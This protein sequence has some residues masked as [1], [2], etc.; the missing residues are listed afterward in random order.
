MQLLFLSAA[1]MSCSASTSS[2]TQLALWRDSRRLGKRLSPCKLHPPFRHPEEALSI[3]YPLTATSDLRQN[4]SGS[5]CTI[6]CTRGVRN[7]ARTG[8]IG[9]R[10]G[11]RNGR[12]ERERGENGTGKLTWCVCA[13]HQ[14]THWQHS[15]AH[16]CLSIA[17][18]YTPCPVV[19]CLACAGWAV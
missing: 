8:E 6:R 3:N 16:N 5:H 12:G 7:R 10:E 11:I 2:C 13:A 15:D 17:H 14:M 18:T 4:S 19:S 1:R 9:L